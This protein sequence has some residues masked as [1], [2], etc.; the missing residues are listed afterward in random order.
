[1]LV[2][3]LLALLVLPY[4]HTRMHAPR[5]RARART[6]THAHA[7]V[8]TH[9]HTHTH[10]FTHTHTH[11]PSSSA[12]QPSLLLKL[13]NGLTKSQH[14]VSSWGETELTI[15]VQTLI[16]V[17]KV[18]A[19]AARVSWITSTSTRLHSLTT[20]PD[21]RPPPPLSTTPLLSLIHI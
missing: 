2:I 7:H 3:P 8:H 5:A 12:L 11:T 19:E 14:G 21:Q 9:V 17:I 13:S 16:L 1:M 4:D 6:H 15:L 10:T 18:Q 20:T